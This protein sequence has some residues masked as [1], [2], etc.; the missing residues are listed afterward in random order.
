MTDDIKTLEELLAAGKR[1]EARELVRRIVAEKMSEEEE[2]K[3]LVDFASVYM[4]VMNNIQERYIA[5]LEAA[6]EG[7]DE[8]DR[9]EGEVVTSEKL[10]VVRKNLEG[11]AQF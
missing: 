7:M 8:L 10:A 1:D 4:E 5:V 9:Q 6:T 2:G 3:A 11:H